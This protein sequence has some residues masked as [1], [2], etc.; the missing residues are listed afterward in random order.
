LNFNVFL[1]R[2]KGI[3]EKRRFVP[4][5]WPILYAVSSNTRQMCAPEHG[6]DES[7]TVF[8]GIFTALLFR[9][10]ALFSGLVAVL[11]GLVLALDVLVVNVASG[12][13]DGRADSRPRPCTAI[14]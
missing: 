10:A 4:G 8:R 6:A 3:S 9:R 14:E 12:A 5:E 2:G 1:F 13:S 7:G 11:V